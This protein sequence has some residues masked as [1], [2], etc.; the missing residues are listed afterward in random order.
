MLLPQEMSKI[1]ILLHK[2]D[3]D[4]LIKKLHEN[5]LMQIE[6]ARIEELKESR[7]N[8]LVEICANY[9]LRLAR[10]IEILKSYEKKKKL[11]D[12]LKEE[13]IKKIKVR[14]KSFDEKVEDVKKI[15]NEVEEEIISKQNEIEKLEEEKE[16]LISK[17]EKL[18]YLSIFDIDISWLGKSKY[19]I[20]KFGISSKGLEISDKIQVYKKPLENEKDKWAF[21]VVAPSYMEKEISKLKMEEIFVEGK[22]RAIDLIR[23][24]KK[25]IED[26]KIKK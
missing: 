19:S 8:P 15:L 4:N 17:L 13:E 2:K 20:I 24:I 10:I 11:R 12:I 6:K 3:S 5:G 22:G 9:E 23:N 16:S 7:I 1:T 14:K 25:K 21:L 18:E 26:I